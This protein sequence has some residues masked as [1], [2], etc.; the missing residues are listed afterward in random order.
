[1]RLLLQEEHTLN[2]QLFNICF[3]KISVPC[4]LKKN[5]LIE[6]ISRERERERGFIK[7]KV[8]RESEEKERKGVVN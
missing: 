1:M 4:A 6:N 2:P 3:L 7:S 8:E 5:I